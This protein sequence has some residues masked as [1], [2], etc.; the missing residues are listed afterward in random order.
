MK[1]KI[2]AV[3]IISL[4]GLT[5]CATLFKGTSENVNM[6]SSPVQA[7]VFINGQLRGK[8]PLQLKL[9]SKNNYAIEFRAEGYQPRVYNISSKVGAGWIVLDVLGGLVPVIIDAATGAWYKLDQDN[10]NAVLEKQQP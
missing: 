6:Q 4:L 3:C 5:G 1:S 8:T 7:E 2:A 9:E 10:I